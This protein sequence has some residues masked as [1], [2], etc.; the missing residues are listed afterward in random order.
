MGVQYMDCN[1]LHGGCNSPHRG[2]T[3][4]IATETTDTEAGNACAEDMLDP[5]VVAKSCTE[6]VIACITTATAH[7]LSSLRNNPR[8]NAAAVLILSFNAI[9]T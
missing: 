4:N 2:Y 1:T 8:Q 5:I 9:L 7:T 6:A 3:A